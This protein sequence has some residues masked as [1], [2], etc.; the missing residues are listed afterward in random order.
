MASGKIRAVSNFVLGLQDLRAGVK[1]DALA[2]LSRLDLATLSDP[3]AL[4]E[5]LEEMVV[6]LAKKHLVSAGKVRPE[7]SRLIKAYVKGMVKPA[8]PE[9]GTGT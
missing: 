4:A 1:E 9:G 7:A 3:A 6:A 8:S 2:L 5:F